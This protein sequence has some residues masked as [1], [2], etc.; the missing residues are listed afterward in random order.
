MAIGARRFRATVILRSGIV[1]YYRSAA[2]SFGIG[3]E[4]LLW[5]WWSS[6]TKAARDRLYAR[7]GVQEFE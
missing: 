3:G 2:L 1:W 6:C 5:G 4:L 7:E